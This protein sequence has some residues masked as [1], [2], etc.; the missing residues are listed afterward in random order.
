MQAA[1]ERNKTAATDFLSKN[2]SKKG[3]QTT[4]SGLQ[5]KVISRIVIAWVLTLPITI[6]ISAT[7]YYLLASPRI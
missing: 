1:G 5:Y 7:L 2:G 4:A 6:V 3:V